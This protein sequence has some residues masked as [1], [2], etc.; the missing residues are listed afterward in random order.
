MNIR[1]Y[2]IQ[3]CYSNRY[4]LITYIVTI[5]CV[6]Y[7]FTYVVFRITHKH[8]NECRICFPFSPS[9]WIKSSGMISPEPVIS[10]SYDKLYVESHVLS[11]GENSPDKTSFDDWMDVL[12]SFI[13]SNYVK[14]DKIHY[15]MTQEQMSAYHSCH[16]NPCYLSCYLRYNYNKQ[17]NI[18]QK[19]IECI[20]TSR[21][22]HFCLEGNEPLKIRYVDFLCTR[23][24]SRKKGITWKTIFT[25]HLDL[26]KYDT[27][28]NS[29]I[30]SIRLFKNE[31]KSFCFAPLVNY[32]SYIF[33]RKYW[34][35]PKAQS[36]Q[37]YKITTI[38]KTNFNWFQ[39]FLSEMKHDSLSNYRLWIHGDFSNIL[40]LIEAHIIYIYTVHVNGQIIGCFIF[41]NGNT[42]YGD[43][44]IL[45]CV[46]SIV[47]D[48]DR[49]NVLLES[50]LHVLYTQRDNYR[51]VSFEGIGHNLL[52]LK[53]L[54]IKYSPLYTIPYY[55]Y[56]EN[57]RIRPLS[58]ENVFILV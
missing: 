4:N 20:I 39:N 10:K 40:H 46:N 57:F 26:H 30:Q 53:Q 37:K 15:H 28:Y 33:D 38:T 49:V 24:K 13:T 21:V 17:T 22:I 6:L 8:W 25:H 42:T 35:L 3:W 29:D 23:H 58:P 43:T 18:I 16:S 52:F 48:K 2:L 56:M 54:L 9:L 47:S 11:P 5:L 44:Q 55:Y 7:I 50:L 36:I 19:T 32:I 31:G 14:T 45:E 12:S 1:E 34:S 51:V 27:L 41:R